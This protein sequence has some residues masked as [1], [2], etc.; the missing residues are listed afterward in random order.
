MATTLNATTLSRTAL[1]ALGSPSAGDVTGNVIPNGGSTFLYIANG[2]SERTLT[3]AFGRTVDGQPVTSRVLTVA[4]NF[5]GFYK[6]G[7]VSDYGANVTVT[8]SNADLT[9]KVFQL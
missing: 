9:L 3:I 5:V 8:P 4:A 2:S 1:T 7:P 6:I